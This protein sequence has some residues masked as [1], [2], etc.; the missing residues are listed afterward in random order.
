LVN[1]DHFKPLGHPPTQL[2]S[3]K[4]GVPVAFKAKEL[5]FSFKPIIHL[6]IRPLSASKR[7][8]DKGNWLFLTDATSL[9]QPIKECGGVTL[10]FCKKYPK[11]VDCHG[12]DWQNIINRPLS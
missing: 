4:I 9:K 1:T 8:S 2:T 11:I 10:C 5:I 7:P 12:A 6:H 3:Q